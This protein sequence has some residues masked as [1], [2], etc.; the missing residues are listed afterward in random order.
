MQSKSNNFQS[1]S[2]GIMLTILVL[3]F[4]TCAPSQS[5]EFVLSDPQP[6]L[7]GTYVDS[8]PEDKEHY[9]A[10][11]GTQQIYP[12]NE[13]ESDL[14]V[15]IMSQYS[16]GESGYVA[17]NLEF[18]KKVL[19]Q[20]IMSKLIFQISK[21][22]PQYLKGPKGEDRYALLHELALVETYLFQTIWLPLRRVIDEADLLSQAQESM[23]EEYFDQLKQEYRIEIND[24]LI[25]ELRNH[26]F[27]LDPELMDPK[28]ENRFWLF[29]VN[30]K[31]YPAWK[32]IR[33]V[34]PASIY[35]ELLTILSS[36]EHFHFS[37][38]D[39]LNDEEHILQSFIEHALLF[40][41]IEDEPLLR[42][43]QLKRHYNLKMLKYVA[44]YY[45]DKDVLQHTLEEI[46]QELIQWRV[47]TL[48]KEKQNTKE[49]EL[50]ERTK[51]QQLIAKKEKEAIDAFQAEL[52]Q[53]YQVKISLPCLNTINL[54]SEELLGN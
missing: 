52:F 53:D 8:I 42:S 15:Y 29:K 26:N 33:Y 12:C 35:G 49:A 17:G 32:V 24:T 2:V 41:I 10:A 34:N 39:Y 31:P 37:L 9:A 54:S 11:I 23:R 46:D 7:I 1:L 48:P 5:D 16:M 44:D 19:E 43:D 30:G 28:N 20:I 3:Y 6:G 4:T 27:L 40:H 47:E 51:Y 18:K 14:A 21:G 50:L 36:R 22:S 25:D 13:Y 38:A 45:M